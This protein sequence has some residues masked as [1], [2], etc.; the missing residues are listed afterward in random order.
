M[1]NNASHL[2]SLIP[3]F[4]SS[5]L[6]A[7]PSNSCVPARGKHPVQQQIQRGMIGRYCRSNRVIRSCH[8]YWMMNVPAICI[9][10]LPRGGR[11]PLLYPFFRDFET[12]DQT[13]GLRKVWK[14]SPRLQSK[15]MTADSPFR[16]GE[17]FRPGGV[18][19]WQSSGFFRR[20]LHD[21]S[22]SQPSGVDARFSTN[23]LIQHF[24]ALGATKVTGKSQQERFF[25]HRLESRTGF[26]L[27]SCNFR[28]GAEL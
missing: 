14:R 9:D 3:G 11:T 6:P 12:A 16:V 25:F 19:F 24:L 27:V 26:P 18:L 4:I 8:P 22:D 5:R 13:F 1:E 23:D 10:S 17:N 21:H 7:G 2:S 15:G 28:S 20:T